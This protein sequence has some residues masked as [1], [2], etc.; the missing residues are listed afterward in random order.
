MN[1]STAI[2]CRVVLML[3]FGLLAAC[4]SAP[5]MVLVSDSG[6]A[7]SAKQSEDAAAA[8]S[9]ETEDAP[10]VADD[11]Q[12]TVL[13]TGANRGLGLEMARQFGADDYFVI[14][15]ARRPEAATE[16]KQLGARVEQL[17]VTDAE[18]VAELARR[19]DGHR[20]DILINNA[21]Y[22]GAVPIGQ[23]QLPL[24][25]VDIDDVTLC[26]EVNTLG[27][28]RVT[29]ALLGNLRAAQTRRVV[30]ISTRSSILERRLR[31]GSY[32]YR[33]SKTGLSMVTRNI[34]GDLQDEG[35]IVVCIAP[36]H[37]QTDMGT[38]RAGMTP[39]ESIRG[40]K[41]VIE[42]LK[43]DQTGR[44]WFHDGSELPW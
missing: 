21:G 42:G 4:G 1:Q 11:G 18:S 22:F 8:A 15:T 19:L 16:L 39:E 23:G 41:K 35:F 30:N 44:F 38:Q 29:Q 33:I 20:I 26:I 13:I 43:P 14:G 25:E 31:M 37:A 2:V 5:P 28:L 24:D 32:G 36:G 6:P 34:A 27:P 10:A 12:L 9:G 40:V 17:D 7:Q 3:V